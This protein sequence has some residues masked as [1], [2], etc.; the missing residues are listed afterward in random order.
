MVK[1]KSKRKHRN[2]ERKPMLR[3]KLNIKTSLGNAQL[4]PDIKVQVYIDGKNSILKEVRDLQKGDRVL[5]K[6]DSIT[7]TLDDVIPLLEENPFYHHAREQIFHRFNNDKDRVTML[8]KHLLEGLVEKRYLDNSPEM[9]EKINQENGQDL[10][11]N[12]KWFAR[13]GL[14]EILKGNT[15]NEEIPST[16]DNWI[17]NKSVLTIGKYLPLLAQVNPALAD[18]SDKE[19][20][21]YQAYQLWSTCRKQVMRR[22]HR[23]SGENDTGSGNGKSNGKDKVNSRVIVNDIVNQVVE[24]YDADTAIAQVVDTHSI[25]PSRESDDLSSITLR[26]NEEPMSPI[27][28][29]MDSKVITEFSQNLLVNYFQEKGVLN[30]D[31]DTMSIVKIFT[32]KALYQRTEDLIGAVEGFSNKEFKDGMQPAEIRNIILEDISSGYLDKINNLPEGTIVKLTQLDKKLIEE[33]RKDFM[34]YQA[35]LLGLNHGDEF[36]SGLEKENEAK[37]LKRLKKNLENKFKVDLKDIGNICT[38][39]EV[40]DYMAREEM[41]NGV[42][43]YIDHEE[44]KY[45][46][47]KKF[48]EKKGLLLI[49]EPKKREI[50]DKYGFTCIGLDAGDYQESKDEAS[51][52]TATNK[53]TYTHLKPDSKKPS[54]R[55]FLRNAAK[56]HNE[57]VSKLMENPDLIEEGFTPQRAEYNFQDGWARADIFG[58]DANLNP[59]I[60]EV[61]QNATRL[62]NGFDNGL[63]A[64]EQVSGYKA[65]LEFDLNYC[66]AGAEKCPLLM[67][68]PEPKARGILVAH[69]IDD[70][71]KQALKKSGCEYKEV[72]K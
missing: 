50:L 63:K 1:Q 52:N 23:G 48:I 61:K 49:S 39:S 11:R 42:G 20:E 72:S 6:K 7:T 27:E 68:R 10:S 22:L 21:K 29:Y 44:H 15:E 40:S 30:T 56:G 26:G 28:T 25:N 47:I 60:V 17:G 36:F 8:R 54:D 18:F 64:G 57:L 46:R 70:N 31:K 67:G 32:N 37:E 16:F 38:H 12:E 35:R 55:R 9:Q 19:G 62:D 24:N 4:S 2:K 45:D 59:V 13:N 3:K 51:S 53:P 43:S 5:F 33:G 69:K 34:I 58:Y 71:V 41:K 66:Q 14:V 65:S